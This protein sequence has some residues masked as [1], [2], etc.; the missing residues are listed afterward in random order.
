MHLAACTGMLQR[1]DLQPFA[2]QSAVSDGV[3]LSL[4]I[5]QEEH[6]AE[7]V[8]V[9][10]C[11]GSVP[12]LSI[13]LLKKHNDIAAIAGCNMSKAW[14]GPMFAQESWRDE[15]SHNGGE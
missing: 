10:Q 2:C 9:S 7:G 11:Y 14:K 8:T 15:G 1:P 5:M 4:M 13:S 3:C 12:N 6:C